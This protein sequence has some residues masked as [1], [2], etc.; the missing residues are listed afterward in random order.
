MSGFSVQPL[1]ERALPEAAGFLAAAIA[2]LDDPTCGIAETAAGPNAG[3]LLE[4]LRW[5]LVSNPMRRS[6]TE[7]G[8][9]LRRH[10]GSLAGTHLVFPWRFRLGSRA[11]FAL[12]SGAIFVDPSARVYGFVLF[13]RFL[14]IEDVDFWFANTC[15]L[16][17]GRLWSKLGG[18]PVPRTEHEDLFPLR[19]GPLAREYALRR[20]W[21]DRAASVFAGAATLGSPLLRLRGRR[22]RLR[23][24]ECDDWERLSDLSARHTPDDALVSDRSPEYFRWC[25]GESPAGERRKTYRLVDPSGREGWFAVGRQIRGLRRQIR[26]VALLDWSLPPDGFDPTDA[27][28]AVLSVARETGDLFFVRG[29]KDARIEDSGLPFRRRTLAGPSGYVI[30]GRGQAESFEASLVVAQA[31]FI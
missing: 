17:S 28:A 6:G 7:L 15:N 10:D 21:G 23:V 27:L 2:S 24:E 9:V 20:G 30:R 4:T 5:R 14:A 29:R 19:A 31:D 1:E 18:R 3:E 22:S 25:Y 13:K 16:N 11:L 8:H 12:G 26:S